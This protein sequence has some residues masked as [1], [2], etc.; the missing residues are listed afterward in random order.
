[1]RGAKPPAREQ[2]PPFVRQAIEQVAEVR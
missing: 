1:L 2:A